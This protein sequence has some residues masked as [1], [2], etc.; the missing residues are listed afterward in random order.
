M[1]WWNSDQLSPFPFM[2]ERKSTDQDRK[3]LIWW[4]ISTLLY[5]PPHIHNLPLLSCRQTR[6]QQ[7]ALS[8]LDTQRGT[9][10]S[11][12][13]SRLDCY[14]WI[15]RWL[16]L[17]P[18]FVRKE[19]KKEIMNIPFLEIKLPALYVRAGKRL[20]SRGLLRSQPG[21]CCWLNFQFSPSVM[22]K[23]KSLS[24]AVIVCFWG[25]R[26]NY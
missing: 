12:H 7:Q 25:E 20:S 18:F 4:T 23:E 3:P 8:L 13:V 19:K 10:F 15:S 26:T 11:A 24:K 21:L 5:T 22:E 2:E 9:L 1:C 6:T 17:F 16:I 14:Y